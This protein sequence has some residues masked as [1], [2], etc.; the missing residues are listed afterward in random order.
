MVVV[1]RREECNGRA[2]D[3][4]RPPPER[5]VSTGSSQVAPRHPR[6]SAYRCFLPDLTGFA[7]S[8]CVGPGYR[9]R[10]ATMVV[11]WRGPRPGI[12]PRYSGLRIQGTA[13][14]P[15]STT[16]PIVPPRADI[17]QLRAC[18][19]R[20][21]EGG[22]RTLDGLPR[23]AFP[24][25]RHRPLGDLSRSTRSHRCGRVAEREGF[26]P[27]VLIAHRFSRAAPS[28]TRT[29]LRRRV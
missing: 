22:I 17:G 6:P 23:T 12:R 28:T 4:D 5:T 7:A 18:G 3:V 29:P 10:Q 2:P 26:E 14:S 13:S 25:R 20:G 8:R 15:P 24:M 9:R 16:V 27:S 11:G 19:P 1:T 21:G